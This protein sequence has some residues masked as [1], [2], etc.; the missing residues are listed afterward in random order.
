MSVGHRKAGTSHRG[1]FADIGLAP[2]H[3]HGGRLDPQVETF[4][5][6]Q[7][8]AAARKVYFSARPT[9]TCLDRMTVESTGPCWEGS[10]NT[11]TT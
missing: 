11:M 7:P 5:P 2:T 1:P 4:S 10:A 8:F 6:S 3:K 9:D